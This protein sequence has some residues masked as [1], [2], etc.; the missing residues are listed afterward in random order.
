MCFQCKPATNTPAA[1]MG[2]DKLVRCPDPAASKT[3][4]NGT[5]TIAPGRN[6][7]EPIDVLKLEIR[8]VAGHQKHQH[9]FHELRGL[10]RETAEL[11]PAG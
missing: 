10:Q 6:R 7:S 4:K 1:S 3:R 9:D 5:A 2:A 8:Q 11:D